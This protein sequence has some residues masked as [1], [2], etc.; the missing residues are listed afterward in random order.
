MKSSISASA[1]AGINF[2]GQVQKGFQVN[3]HAIGGPSRSA[4]A[5]CLPEVWGDLAGSLS[6]PRT[7]AYL[8]PLDSSEDLTLRLSRF[9]GVSGM[10]GIR[11]L[12]RFKHKAR[13]PEDQFH[14]LVFLVNIQC[15]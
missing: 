14:F 5:G 3:T 6:R 7:G 1:I 11:R 12:C 2:V 15:G 13:L 4:G 10:S 8:Q 9:Q